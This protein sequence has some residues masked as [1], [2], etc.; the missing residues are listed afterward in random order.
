M[1]RA[2]GAEECH[3]HTLEQHRA[4]PKHCNKEQRCTDNRPE[5]LKLG[6]G[7][8]GRAQRHQS[9]Q[10]ANVPAQHMGTA[11]KMQESK[12]NPGQCQEL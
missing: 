7:S 5:V 1:L 6:S 2:L 8:A 11:L 9:L 10:G 4:A 12:K 3:K